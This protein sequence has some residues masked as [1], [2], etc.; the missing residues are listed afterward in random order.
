MSQSTLV[1]GGGSGKKP[2]E[3][4]MKRKIKIPMFDNSELIKG[5]SKTVIGRCMNPR[6]QDMK[7]LLF[8]F[9]RIW[10][11]EGKV[12]GADLGLGRFQFDFED[13]G[14]IEE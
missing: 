13:A 11:L 3:M 8:M 10:Q 1:K 14:D 4:V 9:P 6:M 12:V 5:Y 7:T 2:V